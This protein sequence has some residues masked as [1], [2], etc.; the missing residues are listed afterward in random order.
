[1]SQNKLFTGLLVGAAVG[2]I[3]SLFDRNTRQDV[4]QKSKSLSNNVSYYA[5]NREELISKVQQQTEKA[6]NLYSRVSED[7]SYVG[8][9][10]NQLKELTP[11]VKDMALE[12]KEAFTETKDAVLDTKDDV[13]SAVKEENP[14]AESPLLDNDSNGDSSQ[15]NSS[16][17]F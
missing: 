10:V 1:M 16:S 11:Q 2:I 6:Q 8:E 17:N 5:K 7:A 14:D 13:L 12:T 15:K 9:K 4:V 3:I